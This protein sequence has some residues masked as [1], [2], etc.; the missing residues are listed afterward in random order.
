MTELSAVPVRELLATGSTAAIRR[1]DCEVSDRHAYTNF[2]CL[3]ALR[4]V[5]PQ[6]RVALDCAPRQTDDQ[7][8][9]SSLRHPHVHALS[10][11]RV[12]G[13]D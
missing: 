10:A 13:S 3:D 2:T 5:G 6:S 1:F 12:V 9:F 4:R 8:R 7:H 11:T